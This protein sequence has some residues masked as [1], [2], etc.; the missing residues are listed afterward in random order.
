MSGIPYSSYNAA[1]DDPGVFVPADLPRR[2]RFSYRLS[3]GNVAQWLNGAWK[4]ILIIAAILLLCLFTVVVPPRYRWGA[5]GPVYPPG[6]CSAEDVH[7][8]L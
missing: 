8:G 4:D 2:P 5:G 7:S 6:V 3:G 1:S